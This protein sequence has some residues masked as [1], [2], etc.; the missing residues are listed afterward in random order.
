MN[1]PYSKPDVEKIRKPQWTV[2]NTRTT[3]LVHDRLQQAFDDMVRVTGATSIT[4]D[5]RAGIERL[6]AL[7]PG[8]K[9]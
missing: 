5:L 8:V 3:Q 6:R 2:E 4:D 1:T 9:P 7:D